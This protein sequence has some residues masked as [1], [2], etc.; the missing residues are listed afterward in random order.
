M[1][2][3]QAMANGNAPSGLSVGDYVKTNGGMYRI[4]N[5]GDFGASYNS[6][7]G[8]W[9]TK[10][11]ANFDPTAPSGLQS[12]LSSAQKVAQ[13]NAGLS[14]N[15]AREQMQFQTE[16][17]AKAMAFSKEEAEKN[18][19]WQERMSNTAHQRE[20]ADL[21]AAGLNP[22]LTAMGGN[23]AAVTSGASASGVTSGGAS[24]A[25]DNSFNSLLASLIPALL[26]RETNL[27][28]AKLN[29]LTSM[30]MADSSAAASMYASNNSAAATMYAADK[31]GDSVTYSADKQYDSKGDFP[32][33]LPSIGFW[34]LSRLG[35]Y[36]AQGV[37]HMIDLH[38][39]GVYNSR[40]S[41]YYGSN[42]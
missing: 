13:D 6:S 17:N 11:D 40:E 26:N 18:R 27:D 23:G 15:Y 10:A 29:A 12:F 39:K 37:D 41:H 14:Q 19:Q 28:I 32:T 42:R 2:V 5:P 35:E 36:T 9:S 4:A 24:G 7:S 22:V 38:K 33:N 30:Y 31:S 21:I 25:T 34:L 16:A 20:M 1:A 8:Y 3:V